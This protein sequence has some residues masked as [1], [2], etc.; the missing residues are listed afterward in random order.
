MANIDTAFLDSFNRENGEHDGNITFEEALVH[1]NGL[2][3]NGP[4]SK[5][6]KSDR[7][8]GDVNIGDIPLRDMSDT[9]GK[10]EQ[11]VDINLN[12]ALDPTQS[13]WDNTIYRLCSQAKYSELPPPFCLQKEPNCPYSLQIILIPSTTVFLLIKTESISIWSSTSTCTRTSFGQKIAWPF[14]KDCL[15]AS[16]GEHNLEVA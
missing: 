9:A 14:A 6:L 2:K 12:L 16:I 1:V 5:P 13:F 11:F 3:L 7:A 4:L 15:C 8:P 10:V